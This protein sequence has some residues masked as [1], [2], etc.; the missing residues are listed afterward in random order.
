MRIWGNILVRYKALK[1]EI[2]TTWHCLLMSNLRLLLWHSLILSLKLDWWVGSVIVAFGLAVLNRA[3]IAAH[4]RL[5]LISVRWVWWE[6]R[7]WKG[8]HIC[9]LRHIDFVL[10]VGVRLNF[11]WVRHV[12]PYLAH[13][14]LGCVHRSWCAIEALM[15][16]DVHLVLR[17]WALSWIL[18]LHCSAWHFFLLLEKRHVRL[19]LLIKL[20]IVMLLNLLLLSILLQCLLSVHH[21][22]V[23]H[24]KL[25]WSYKE[26]II[27]SVACGYYFYIDG[28]H[29]ELSQKFKKRMA[30]IVFKVE[31][32]TKSLAKEN[33]KLVALNT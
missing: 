33:G 22:V 20:L 19:L 3:R 26:G 25:L 17:E 6:R 24:E 8:I 12:I 4:L 1:W 11:W 27:L 13:I 15:I 31:V 32:C 21:L 23:V 2:C 5:A 14:D 7:L 16:R 29:D 9:S 10:S 28:W 18:S 30:S